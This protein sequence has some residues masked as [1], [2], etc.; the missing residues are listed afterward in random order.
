MPRRRTDATPVALAPAASVSFA[1]R[2]Q[3]SYWVARSKVNDSDE[4]KKYADEVPPILAK[5]GGKPLARPE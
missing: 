5:R 4:Y 3:A 2:N 1:R